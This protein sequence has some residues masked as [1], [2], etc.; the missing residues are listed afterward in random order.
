MLGLA[1]VFAVLT[2]NAPASVVSA[3]PRAG[4]CGRVDLSRL[5]DGEDT[6]T[7]NPVYLL[8]EVDA[9]LDE[10]N[11]K[12][13]SRAVVALFK[14]HGQVLCVS[15]HGEFQ[16]CA[17]ATISVIMQADGSSKIG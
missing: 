17:G 9:A 16:K 4:S 2:I 6:G 13:V 10:T 7:G 5:L 15:H 12:L 3:L 8:D 14:G 1:F 11:Q